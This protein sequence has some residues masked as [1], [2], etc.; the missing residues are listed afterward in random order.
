VQ[1]LARRQAAQ[2]RAFCAR[3]YG[4][5]FQM[6]RIP[7]GA[8]CSRLDFED[9][10]SEEGQDGGPVSGQGAQASRAAE[11]ARDVREKFELS[12]H[13]LRSC[14]DEAALARRRGLQLKSS[15]HAA[16]ASASPAPNDSPAMSSGRERQD[17]DPDEE[18]RDAHQTMMRH[19]LRGS[20][21]VVA[22]LDYCQ[23]L[24]EADFPVTP[25]QRH[26]GYLGPRAQQASRRRRL[27][28]VALTL[29]DLCKSAPDDSATAECA[30]PSRGR[31]A[32]ALS[33]VNGSRSAMPS[34]GRSTSLNRT[35]R[36]CVPN[37]DADAALMELLRAL[38][39]PEQV[40]AAPDFAASH[41]D[42]GSERETSVASGELDRVRQMLVD[43]SK[44]LPRLLRQALA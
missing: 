33:A 23:H 24:R 31:P 26:A 41:M 16:S 39:C 32:P 4:K 12:T 19:I 5:D 8:A 14:V 11:A 21:L 40:E 38:T 28:A 10:A 6:D 34:Q 42:D 43:L 27:Q 36:E 37:V 3:V 25:K 44:P 35:R 18:L 13:A 15:S 20:E 9:D 7:V 30:D 2:A 22:W 29:H 17:A 1:G